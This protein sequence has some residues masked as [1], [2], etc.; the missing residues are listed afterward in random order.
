METREI[1]WIHEYSNDFYVSAGVPFILVRLVLFGI[2]EERTET[3][4]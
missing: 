3:F 1:N 2:M 4:V